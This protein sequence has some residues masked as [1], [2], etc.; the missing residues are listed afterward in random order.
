[1]KYHFN[2][3]NSIFI[4]VLFCAFLALLLFA[5]GKFSAQAAAYNHYCKVLSNPYSPTDLSV[6]TDPVDANCEPGGQDDLA[7]TSVSDKTT[8]IAAIED[9]LVNGYGFQKIG[10]QYII[11]GIGND[12]NASWQVRVNNPNV[13]IT[14]EDYAYATNSAYYNVD[15][16]VVTYSHSG[17]APSIVFR[18]DGVIVYAIKINCGNPLGNLPGLP[19]DLCPNLPG[20]QSAIPFGYVKD[21]NGDC[22]RQPVS[23]IGTGS[24]LS[25]TVTATASDPDYSGSITVEIWGD[26]P[27]GSGTF[28]GSAITSG[29][30]ITFVDPN[31]AKLI[32]S[33]RSYYFRA[34]GV[35]TAGNQNGVYTVAGPITLPSCNSSSCGLQTFASSG[36]IVGLPH[37]FEVNAQLIAWTTPP[38]T[39]GTS[40]A[41]YLQ[42]RDPS[43]A[44]VFNNASVAYSETGIMPAFLRYTYTFTPTVGGIYTMVWGLSGAGLNISCPASGGPVTNTAMYAPYFS[45]TGG[46][47]LSGGDIQSWNGDN[48]PAW[49]IGYNGAGT[50]LAALATG[51]ISNFVTG[52][53]LPGG[54]SAQSGHG[55][56]F[57]NTTF[58]GGTYGGGYNVPNYTPPVPVSSATAS[59]GTLD[60]GSFAPGDYDLTYSGDL[61]I[62]GTLH[63]G[64]RL[65][66]NLTSGNLYIA[67]PGISY[68]IY[69]SAADVPRLNVFVL[70]GD[71]FTDND[72][73]TMRGVYYT[74]DSDGNGSGGTFYSCSYGLG[75]AVNLQTSA[76]GYS[77]CYHKL[78]VY[79]AVVA[80]RLV[81]NRTWGNLGSFK[82]ASAVPADP[83]EEFIYSAELW[84]S[85]GGSASGIGP[86]KYDSYVSLPPIL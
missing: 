14:I 79:G 13:T 63:H 78:T 75:S 60:V 83:G 71:I 57:A 61:T 2:K 33:G 3:K 58:G 82:T 53:S 18:V 15:N 70:N 45:V 74:G 80:K 76:S 62:F 20:D 67:N 23:N 32:T 42:I 73:N 81:L 6:N 11:D 56:A 50:N 48:N 65:T 40:P 41:M 35:N 36:M 17:V 72:V 22:D 7:L 34:V 27:P 84:M 51:S 16:R 59:P 30:S 52:I 46:D 31:P 4:S 28:L 19:V 37:S 64:V 85:R 5:P 38:Y 44:L 43:G 29:G 25:R 10:A 69:N 12:A 8:F 77:D 39:A 47:I 24:C 9:K 54:V 26:G 86:V 68:G 55:L 66:I 49:G 1:M 21:S